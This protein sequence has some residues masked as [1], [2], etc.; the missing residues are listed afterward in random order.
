MSRRTPRP[1]HLKL[2]SQA[3]VQ[4]NARV[5]LGDGSTRILESPEQRAHFL[6]VMRSSPVVEMRKLADSIQIN[7]ETSEQRRSIAR[8]IEQH[9]LNVHDVADEYKRIVKSLGTLAAGQHIPRLMEQTAE[10]ALNRDASCPDCRGKGFTER[11]II[12]HE[13]EQKQREACSRCSGTGTIV[14]AGDKE[15]LRITFETF[16]LLGGHGPAVNIDLR[17]TRKHETLEQLSESIAPLLEGSGEL[18]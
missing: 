18:K 1:R 15:S 13:R 14:V 10:D 4:H 3:A 9:G 17:D 16:G 8:L 2:G 11:K 12:K 7:N 5:L 6:E